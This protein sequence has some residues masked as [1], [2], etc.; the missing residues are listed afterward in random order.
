MMVSGNPE[1]IYVMNDAD[2]SEK[3]QLVGSADVLLEA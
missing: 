3:Q 2:S 1:V